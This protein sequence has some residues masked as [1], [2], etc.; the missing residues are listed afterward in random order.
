V[1]H[2]AAYAATGLEWDYTAIECDEVSLPALLDR[3][4][5]EP[6]WRGLSLTM[7]L[8]V[9]ALELVDDLTDDVRSV[10]AL[11]TIVVS[12]HPGEAVR[13]AG[14]NTDIH[15]I[16]EAVAETG[17]VPDYA[18]VLGAG[19]TARAA[20]AALA[21]SGALSVVV[22]ARDVRRTEPLLELGE[23]LGIDVEG[24]P[25]TSIR[26]QLSSADFVIATT[27]AGATDFLA[28]A[29][30]WPHRVPLVDVLYD[31][32]PTRLAAYA[33]SRGSAVVG[34]LSVLAHQAAAQFTLMSGWPAPLAV[35]RSAGEQA[36]AD[37]RAI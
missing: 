17:V 6:G 2:R 30:F 3:V 8:K 18:V 20:V 28:D 32:W 4:R 29:R 33:A 37:R 26:E 10:G 24:A 34:G 5:S 23:R 15:G 16:R 19:G 12:G 36:L 13:L 22:V 21:E 14:H 27:P 11:N 7:P 25:W 35:I 9:A 1:L 31:P